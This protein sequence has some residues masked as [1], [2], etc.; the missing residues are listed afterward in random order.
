M[1]SAKRKARLALIAELKKNHGSAW[2]SFLPDNLRKG[3]TRVNPDASPPV[4][5]SPTPRAPTP[6]DKGKK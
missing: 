6:D 5:P 2:R 1:W 4:N 3:L